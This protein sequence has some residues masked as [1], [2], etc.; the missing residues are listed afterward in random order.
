MRFY[1]I[2]DA[3]NQSGSD[4]IRH[5]LTTPVQERVWTISTGYALPSY[6]SGA[7]SPIITDNLNGA[8]G[9]EIALTDT[10]FTVSTGRALVNEPIGSIGEGVFSTDMMSEV[11]QDDPPRKSPPTT[12]TSSSRSTGL[13]HRR[14]GPRGH[15]RRRADRCRVRRLLCSP[16]VEEGRMA[17]RTIPRTPQVAAPTRTASVLKRSKRFLGRDWPVAYIFIAPLVILLFGL[18]AY[19][20]MRGVI[21]SFYNYT[22]ITNRGFVGLD[23]YERL[24]SNRQFRSSVWITVQYATIA[25]FFK[26]WIGL[27][28]AAAPPQEPPL[29]QRFHGA[30]LL[31]WVIPTSSRP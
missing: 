26:F 7:D 6:A 3:K 31:P 30:V 18:I 4:V 25:V 11:I 29:P 5:F 1:L 2:T 24:W 20:L 15:V 27:I 28:A 8:R 14:V 22:G 9:M 21:L 16:N 10:G 17:I 19:P 12:T 13:R 23:N